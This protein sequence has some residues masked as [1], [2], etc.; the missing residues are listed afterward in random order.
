MDCSSVLIEFKKVE[1]PETT[2]DTLPPETPPTVPEPVP[3]DPT[4]TDL[5][6]TTSETVPATTDEPAAETPPAE[7]VVEK[8]IQMNVTGVIGNG[9]FAEYITR[10]GPSVAKKDRHR[11]MMVMSSR[12]GSVSAT[13]A[14][15][16]VL[17][18]WPEPTVVIAGSLNASAATLFIAAAP[19]RLAF[20]NARFM[21]HDSRSCNDGTI[22]EQEETL[23][24]HKEERV[25]WTQLYQDYIGLTKKE[26]ERIVVKDTFFNAHQALEL[27]TKGLIDGIILKLL[28]GFKYEILMRN[29]I[30]KVVDLHNDDFNQIKDLTVEAIKDQSIVEV[31]K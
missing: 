1:P 26:I 14:A 20:P 31:N 2:K 8:M 25:I 21:L 12:G 23:R 19:L 10:L 6:A 4:K 22:A 7:E 15:L 17:A 13:F 11:V 28:D 18:A 3:A 24:V 30:R 16:D 5:P 27:G 29:G 9:T